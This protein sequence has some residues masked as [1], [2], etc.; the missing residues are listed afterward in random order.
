MSLRR[1]GISRFTP[2]LLVLSLVI[3]LGF[4]NT[5][6][7]SQATSSATLIGLVT[8]EQ[9]AAVAGA[10]VRVVDSAT[11]ATNT[12]LTNDTG[13]YVIVNVSPG[14]YSIYVS[15]QGFTVHKVNARICRPPMRP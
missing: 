10:E 6:A 4:G 12:T 5:A 14:T 3:F 13:R 2:G 1:I 11:G 7:W 8:D 15:K 9:N